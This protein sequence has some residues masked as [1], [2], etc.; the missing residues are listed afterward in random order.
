MSETVTQ[1][2]Q[3]TGY[4]TQEIYS[5]EE[6]AKALDMTVEEMY[7]HL[8]PSEYGMPD[9]ERIP[10]AYHAHPAATGD[11]FSFNQGAYERNIETANS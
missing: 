1:F 2:Y 5:E 6:M 4:S 7:H 10:L 9:G 11:E 3:L 8:D